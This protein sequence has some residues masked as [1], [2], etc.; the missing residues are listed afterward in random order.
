MADYTMPDNVQ[1]RLRY[2]DGQ[3]LRDQDFIDE[4]NYHLD[5]QQRHNRLLH[6]PGIVSGLEVI[7][8]PETGEVTI[9]PGTALDSAGRQIVLSK[10]TKL[11]LESTVAG[12]ALLVYIAF[13]QETAD[14]AQT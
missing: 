3:F 12:Q 4:Q 5:R 8:K 9:A 6:A 7:V 1:K 10:E 11:N 2:F 13:A 14:L